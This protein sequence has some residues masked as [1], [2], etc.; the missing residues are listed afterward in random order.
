[1]VGTYHLAYTHL[2]FEALKPPRQRLDKKG[3]PEQANHDS[4]N[5]EEPAKREGY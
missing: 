5:K 4:G 1:M 2:S 3:N